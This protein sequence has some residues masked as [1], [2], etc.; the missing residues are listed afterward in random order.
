MKIQL[1]IT[2]VS[3]QETEQYLRETPVALGRDP[4]AMPREINGEAVS[5]V[6]L[7]DGLVSDYHA[8]IEENNGEAIVVDCNSSTGI[9][10]NRVQLPSSTLVNGDRLQIGSYT[11]LVQIGSGITGDNREGCNLKV[12]F[13]FKHPCGRLDPTGCPYCEGGQR[14]RE[15]DYHEYSYYSGYG[16][17]DNWG[18][19]YYTHRHSYWYDR[20]SDRVD[21]TEA[22]NE[23]FETENDTDFETD[24]GA[25]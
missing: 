21:F 8:V 1:V 22:D 9:E 20:H 10:I 15:V 5:Q 3:T 14:D 11:I 25:S 24:M 17:Y 6:V 2:N 16:R 19:Y 23:A 7:D 18:S 13:L 12:G 4:N